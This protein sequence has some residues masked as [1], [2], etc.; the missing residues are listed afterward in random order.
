MTNIADEDQ[1]KKHRREA[2]TQ[3]EREAEN[4]RW[5]LGDARGR[6]V[7]WN[8]LA[9]CGVF[10]TS[11]TGNS[12]TFFNEG[13]RDIGLRLLATINDVDPAAYLKMVEESKARSS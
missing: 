7:V 9:E 8:L 5:L 4:W 3:Q 1:V 6:E 10:K 2:Q 11:F 13:R 12:T